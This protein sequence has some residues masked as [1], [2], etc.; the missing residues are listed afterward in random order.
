MS[1]SNLGKFCLLLFYCG[2][3]LIGNK[4][5]V[6]SLKAI[7]F[8]LVLLTGGGLQRIQR[9]YKSH[10]R[11]LPLVQKMRVHLRVTLV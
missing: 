11:E 6:S 1:S 5:R 10:L 4:F 9:S 3:C 8:L 7:K 2:R